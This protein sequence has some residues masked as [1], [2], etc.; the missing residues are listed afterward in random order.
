MDFGRSTDTEIMG[1]SS[2][3]AD[4]AEVVDVFVQARPGEYALLAGCIASLRANLKT[5]IGNLCVVSAVLPSEIAGQLQAD[6]CSWLNERDPFG[7][8]AGAIS[9]NPAARERL[10][11]QF[12]KW[13]L[14]RFSR[15]PSYLVIE[16][17]AVLNEPVALV[18]DG[19]QTLFCDN[20]FRFGYLMCFNYFF[21]QIP[22]PASPAMGE[23]QQFDCDVVDEMVQK[24][25]LKY[26]MPWAVATFE[27]L[28]QIKGTAFDAGQNYGHYLNLFRPKS[29]KVQP[30]PL[31]RYSEAPDSANTAA[32]NIVR[33]STLGYNGRFGN[34][35]F[36]YAYLKHYAQQENLTPECPPWIGNS[37]FGQQTQ[38]SEHELPIYREHKGAIDD[39]I[40]F[41]PQQH[42]KN[43]ELW[44]YFQDTY[45]WAE[46]KA[47]FWDLF[48][49]LPFVK[50][51]LDAA[52]GRLRAGNRT[53][54]GIHIRR[55]DYDGGG[56]ASWPAP[57]AWY[58]RWLQGLWPTLCDPILYVATD[59]PGNV[60]PH[61]AG[62]SPKSGSDLNVAINGA[63]Y[64]SDFYV[65]SQCDVLGIS[66]STFSF[67]AA[68][69]NQTAAVFSRPDPIQ[70]AMV[71][72]DPWSSP[73]HLRKQ[74]ATVTLLAA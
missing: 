70:Q 49:P 29:F 19:R 42:R 38:L 63:E 73:V 39:M 46:N 14:R 13:E 74:A 44:G 27:I 61:F 64:Y 10:F 40:Q 18:S 16:A 43:F 22:Y 55:G 25:Q 47:A 21:G 28:R 59:D 45:H 30:T 65:L 60:L 15:T 2:T 32:A 1:R 24:V 11:G 8:D 66:N 5:P 12:L 51:P 62:Y 69:M 52:I 17:S 37:L 6:R 53:L 23:I 4:A 36:Q 35:L 34:Q 54:V 71:Q 9:G 33:M 31:L 67:A 48:Q 56:P 3:P 68:M 50:D 26:G 58:L 57:E 41:D 72:F 20:R 7:F